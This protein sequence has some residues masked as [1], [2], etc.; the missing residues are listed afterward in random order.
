MNGSAESA[1]CF[2]PHAGMSAHELDLQSAQGC[3]CFMNGK[4]KS[5]P[6]LVLSQA[7]CCWQSLPLQDLYIRESI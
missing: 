3:S 6:L 7:K 1:G 2:M 4:K 5:S